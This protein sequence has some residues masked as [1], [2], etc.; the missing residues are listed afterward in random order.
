MDISFNTPKGCPQK[1]LCNKTV[2]LCGTCLHASQVNNMVYGLMAKLVGVWGWVADVGADWA[3]VLAGGS[4]EG[5][6]QWASYDIGGSIAEAEPSS[7]TELC[8]SIKPEDLQASSANGKYK[9]CKKC[10]RPSP[11]IAS[12]DFSKTTWVGK[13]GKN[14]SYS[15]E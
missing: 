3:G 12:K 5:P 9:K 13:K 10:P 8:S 2:M 11:G 14:Y 6:M 1:R 15:A 7:V 4:P